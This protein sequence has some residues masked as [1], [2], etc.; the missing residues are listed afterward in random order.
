MRHSLSRALHS[1]SICSPHPWSSAFSPKS[2]P[3]LHTLFVFEIQP[4]F[5]K[6]H[7]NCTRDDPSGEPN[8]RNTSPPTAAHSAR[9]PQRRNYFPVARCRSG[10]KPE[11]KGSAALKARMQRATAASGMK[12]TTS[13]SSLS[14]GVAHAFT[15][16][17]ASSGYNAAL[18][19]AAFR[20]SRRLHGL[21]LHDLSHIAWKEALSYNT[22]GVACPTT[23][24]SLSNAAHR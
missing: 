2:F 6:K 22:G 4:I 23:G 17:L 19:S 13:V 9:S 14:Y 11:K 16:L 15:R 7:D 8:W 24:P 21:P 1:Q 20:F 3:R 18:P 12:L 10:R 5:D